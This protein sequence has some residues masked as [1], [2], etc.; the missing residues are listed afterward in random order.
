[1]APLLPFVV[2][3]RRRGHAAGYWLGPTA[4]A[5]LGDWS[6]NVPRFASIHDATAA[7]DRV[8]GWKPGRT[9]HAIPAAEAGPL[10]PV[11]H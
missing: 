9:W 7:A 3:V 1:M 11:D 2:L 5:R 8:L 4:G 6:D 10:I